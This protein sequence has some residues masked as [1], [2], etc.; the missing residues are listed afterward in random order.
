[1]AGAAQGAPAVE[2]AGVRIEP[3]RRQR[4]RPGLANS[5]PSSSRNGG[6]MAW[7]RKASPFFRTTP[8]SLPQTSTTN[9]S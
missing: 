2:G 4:A 5:A 3:R 9:G 6:A 1:M 7:K 8:A